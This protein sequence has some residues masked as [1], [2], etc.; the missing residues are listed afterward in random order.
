MSLNTQNDRFNIRNAAGDIAAAFMFLTRLPVRGDDRPMSQAA[1][2]FPLV[3]LG[4]GVIGGIVLAV[5][6]SLHLPPLVSAALA[7]AT[8]AMATGAL[9]ED[10][11]AD[12]ADG[13][14][15]GQDA[16]RRLEIMRDSRVGGYGA[17]A[18]AL[19]S[20]AKAG[21]IAALTSSGGAATAVGAMIAAHVLG[22]G[23]MVA[24]MHL[25]P[26]A[27]SSGQAA[28][29][30]A[31]DR[32]RTVIAIA[33]AVV[34]STLFVPLPALGPAVIVAAAVTIGA[35]FLVQSKLGG[36][37]GDTLGG[38]EQLVELAVLATLASFALQS[39]GATGAAGTGM[40][41]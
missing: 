37:N 29:H 35:G 26:R 11:L 39:A 27:S 41:T 7:L 10:G 36:Y 14:W 25:L 28:A 24:M 20:L 12:C 9:H 15:S 33:I 31:P 2:S 30:G 32:T 13:L 6:H 21:A 38:T 8:T 23:A 17:L 22:R 16:A 40:L 34:S 4:V 19:T 3:G 1:W 5:G 18:L